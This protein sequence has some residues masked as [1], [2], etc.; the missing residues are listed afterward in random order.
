MSTPIRASTQEHLDIDDVRDHLVLFKDGGVSLV[1]QTTAVNFGLLSETEQDAMMYAFAATLNSLS[2][3]IQIVIRSQKYDITTYIERLR[4]AELRQQ[5]QKFRSQMTRYRAFVESTIQ[6]NNV[7]DKRFYIVIPFSPIELGL[8]STF[9]IF[10]S[11]KVPYSKTYILE[12]AK[13]ALMP[14]R[15]HL[16]RSLSRVGLKG[17]QLSTEQLISLYHDIYNPETARGQ[18]VGMHIDSFTAPLMQRT[19]AELPPPAQEEPPIQPPQGSTELSGAK[20]THSGP[21]TPDTIRHTLTQL[22]SAIQRLRG[23][24]I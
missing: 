20:G 9:G 21:P 7:L 24:K 4:Q 22:D 19:G 23:G 18:H 12:K 1:L 5:N 17:M 11:R 14:R 8:G 16:L 13:T 15:D 2:F 6:E 3:P 10:G